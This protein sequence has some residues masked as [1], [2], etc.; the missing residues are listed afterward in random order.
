MRKL[1][2]LL[3]FILLAYGS[4]AQWE[5]QASGFAIQRGINQI[6][7]IDPNTVWAS[8]FDPANA[9]NKC[10]DFTMTTDGGNTWTADIVDGAPTTYN[11]SCLAATS[12]DSAWSA[13]YN[14]TAPGG[15]V[16][17][18]TNGGTTW[19]QQTVFGTTSFPDVIY[20]WN[21]SKGVTMGDPVNGEF[22]I[23]TTL[24]GGGTWTAVAGSDIP[25]PQDANEY[26][27]TRS[28]AV[29]GNTIWFGTNEGRLFKS[30]DFGATWTVYTT[31]NVNNIVQITFADDN[32]GWLEVATGSSYT[33]LRTTDGGI[34]WTDITPASFYGFDGL[35]YVPYT[36]NTLVAT[37]Y[38][39][40]NAVFGSQYSV[41]GGDTWV[42]IDNDVTHLAVSFL[43]NV[44][45]WSGDVNVDATTGG[46]WKYTDAFIAD[47]INNP[48]PFVK[49]NLY[50]NPSNGLFYFSFE[51]QNNQPI[52]I[53]VTDMEGKMVFDKV[54]NDKSQTWLR[55]IDLRSF[56]KGIYFLDLEN[57]GYHSTEKLVVN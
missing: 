17:Q 37:G 12:A 55:S 52:H 18:T 7:T 26:G 1:L 16:Y 31:G 22:E 36:I 38:D 50:P 4:N 11:W 6:I 47:G 2:L 56:S 33:L 10:R 57:N 20:F 45:G 23:Y 13:M 42:E 53:Q 41:D 27:L 48:D 49:F 25:D 14:T 39:P 5:S 3:S 46:M 24:D 40:I 8:G 54:Y 19:T 44:T 30:L 29:R 34:S 51:A 32:N 9:N 35:T 15:S 21:S 28:F 43:N